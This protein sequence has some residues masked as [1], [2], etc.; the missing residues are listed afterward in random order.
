VAAGSSTLLWNGAGRGG[1]A[2]AS[3]LYLARFTRGKTAHEA[4][5]LIAP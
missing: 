3:G 2:L 5:V 4:R 1:E